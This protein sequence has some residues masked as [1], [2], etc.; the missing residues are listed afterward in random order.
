LVV[1]LGVTSTSDYLSGTEKLLPA[2]GNRG[3]DRRSGQENQFAGSVST[4][5][6]KHTGKQFLGIPLREGD[7]ATPAG[8][9]LLH[10]KS[11]EP[12]R[13]ARLYCVRGSDR[14]VATGVQ[15]IGCNPGPLAEWPCSVRVC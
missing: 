5:G 15:H 13:L 12:V 1:A 8:R 6:T 9:A 3:W 11:V 4:V 7:Q 14:E 2:F 10:L